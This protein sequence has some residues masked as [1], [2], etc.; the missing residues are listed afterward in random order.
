MIAHALLAVI[1][2]HEHIR[3]PASD[4]LIALTC[5]EFRR[6]FELCIIEPSRIMACPEAWSQWRRHR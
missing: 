3:Q 6:L 2:A 5:N 4:G 1:A